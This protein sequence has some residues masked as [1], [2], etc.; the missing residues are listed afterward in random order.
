MFLR[1]ALL[2]CSQL[3][4]EVAA[5]YDE[6]AA[7]PV[8][9]I[10]MAATWAESARKERSRARLLHALAEISSALEDDGPFL[11]QVPVQLSSLRRV[12]ES[13]HERVTSVMD[14]PTAARCAE[15][16][17]GT[18]RGELH[19]GLLEVAEPEIRR[20]LR[21][22]D[23]ETRTLRRGGAESARSRYSTR[24]RDTTRT[25]GSCALSST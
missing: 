1:E 24:S 8:A 3:E 16:L 21:L 6:L 22:I 9:A 2:R 20:V 13:V 7:S 15:A 10:E 4:D 5:V 11:V 25:R 18:Q 17:E 23:S 12:V 14:A 19:A